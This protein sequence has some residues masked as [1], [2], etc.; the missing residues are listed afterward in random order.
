MDPAE[1][2]PPDQPRALEHPKVP[3]D[4][5]RRDRERGRQ[6]AHREAAA[7]QPLHDGAP[8]RIGEG[9]E[10]RVERG[11]FLI[12]HVVNHRSGGNAAQARN[13]ERAGRPMAPRGLTPRGPGTSV[14]GVGRERGTGCLKLGTRRKSVRAR[15][16]AGFAAPGTTLRFEWRCRPVVSSPARLR[17]RFVIALRILSLVASSAFAC[18]GPSIPAAT[19]RTAPLFS[20]PFL[21]LR[22]PDNPYAIAAAD[23]DHDVHVDVVTVGPESCCVMLGAGDGTVRSRACVPIAGSRYQ[24]MAAEIADFDRDGA[25]DLAFTAYFAN[26]V[27]IM[28]GDGRGGFGKSTLVQV[29]DAPFGL[30]VGDFNGDG[31]PDLVTA[32]DSSSVS[33]LLGRGDGTF[34]PAAN[35]ATGLDARS[36]AIGDVNGDG[37]PDLVTAN[38]NTI[39]VLLGNGAGGFAPHVDELEPKAVSV[40]L[41]DLD[42]DGHLDVVTSTET[43]VSVRLGHGD[44]TFDPPVEYAAHG[45]GY[46]VRVAD[47]DGDGALDV[48]LAINQFSSASVYLGDGTGRL[49]ARSEHFAGESPFDM[50]IADFDGDGH[51]DLLVDV[52]SGA[53]MVAVLQNAGGG[54]FG[55]GTVIPVAA[56]PTWLDVG[57]VDE[58]GIPDLVTGDT[59]SKTLTF[60][61]G[62][63]AGRF[64]ARVDSLVG[65]PLGAVLRDMDGDGHL[66]VATSTT[67]ALLVLRG[68]GDGTFDAPVSTPAPSGTIRFAIADMNGD[69]RPDYV[70]LTQQGAFD[71]IEVM[72]ARGDGTFT[73][74]TALAAGLYGGWIAIGDLDGDGVPD[75]VVTHSASSVVSVFMGHHDGMLGS[76]RD[77]SIPTVAPFGLVRDVTGDGKADV[78]LPGYLLPGNGDGTFGPGS[79]F[80]CGA[81]PECVAAG[82]VDGDGIL[83]LVTAN[84]SDGT[85]TVARGLGGGTF[86]RS[87]DLG[88]GQ[89]AWSVAITDLNGDGRPDLVLT[90]CWSASVTVLPNTGGRAWASVGDR[91]DAGRTGVLAISPNPVARE[92]RIGFRLPARRD[93]RVGVFDVEG[94]R[95]ATL[96]SGVWGAGDH[97]V[98][99]D[100]RGDDGRCVATGLYWV[101]LR[102]GPLRATSRLV[103]V[104]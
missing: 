41:G 56:G 48:A 32:N 79:Y 72:L 63:G 12:N 92:A 7:R 39:S 27:V 85:A 60:V 65:D 78:V 93:T 25:P 54:R 34:A 67:T 30:A 103:V 38:R 102:C 21:A 51:P 46:R 9:S 97:V 81:Y 62:L 36:V 76:R 75:V 68:H 5:G 47:L 95:V 44:G 98:K 53:G 24:P 3:R 35:F 26:A 2:V 77:V 19:A 31:I 20:S 71:S 10:C 57:D 15:A 43:T 17:P 64:E 58:D 40:A 101:E 99:W 66:D 82:D 11:C 94:R 42:H 90:N 37:I 6:V 104:R 8:G 87:A 80:P 13:D 28:A 16:A 55:G 96:G 18:L 14:F 100:L 1:H 45:A 88:S 52:C 33:V 61:H 83:D 73:R 23:L 4:G 84:S 22:T 50:V 59:G 70:V 49:G 89:G 74:G 86:E 29:G 91:A 69:G